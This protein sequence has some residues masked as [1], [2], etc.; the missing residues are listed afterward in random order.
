MAPGKRT[1]P[2]TKGSN[3]TNGTNGTFRRYKADPVGFVQEVL[4]GSGLPYPKQIEILEA[5]S[6]SRR[7]SVV[8]CNGS[9]KDWAAARVVLW[10]L[11]TRAKSKAV[12][13][14]PTQRQVEEVVWREMR[15]AYGAAEGLPGLMYTSRYVIND[16][17]FA[18]GFST[19]HPYNLQGFH[20]PN[21]LVVVTEA[22]AVAQ[23]HM[24]AL[25]R[26]NPRLLLFT[27]NPLTMGGEFYDSHHSKRDLYAQV[28]ISAFDTANVREGQDDLVPGMTTRQDIEE[29]RQEWGEENPMYRASVLGEFPEALAD[30]LIPLR[31]VTEAVSRWRPS[32]AGLWWSTRRSANGTRRIPVSLRRP[33]QAEGLVA[34]GRPSQRHRG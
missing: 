6:H 26:L 7:V 3:S 29:R 32:P 1:P 11:A 27:G 18:L 4:G 9:G 24:E 30:T 2:K 25:K 12:V 15:T 16:E 17:R 5:A 31:P 28:A 14:G 33:D 8:G 20:S 13:T 23:E 21:L 34:A 19:D 10:W 22:H